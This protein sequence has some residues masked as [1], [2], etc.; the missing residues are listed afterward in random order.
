MTGNRKRANPSDGP[1]PSC[2]LTGGTNDIANRYIESTNFPIA[3]YRIHRKN[4]EY[5]YV[6]TLAT[7]AVEGFTDDLPDVLAEY[8][9]APTVTKQ[10]V[11]QLCERIK[12]AI[13][14]MVHGPL[15]DVQVAFPTMRGITSYG[16][17]RGPLAADSARASILTIHVNHRGQLT[18]IYSR[19]TAVDMAVKGAVFYGQ[20][21][22]HA[23]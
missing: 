8:P 2:V 20:G 21:G 4:L 13:V 7:L 14:E 22:N 17:H 18:E 11:D 16:L 9:G 10:T 12:R 15:A 6:L 1:S 19:P 3:A 23:H 5:Y